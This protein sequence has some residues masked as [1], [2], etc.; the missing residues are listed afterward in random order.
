MRLER[1]LLGKASL[2]DFEEYWGLAIVSLVQYCMLRS[3][4]IDYGLRTLDM[5][6][7]S[8]LVSTNF[9]VGFESVGVSRVL[10]KADRL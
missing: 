5:T 6:P 9:F 10:K 7:Q 2:S 3:L 1:G 4:Y 8:I